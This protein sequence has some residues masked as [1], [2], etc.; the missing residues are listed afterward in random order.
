MRQI[1]TSIRLALSALLRSKIRSALTSLG[2]LIGIAAVVVVTALG[3]GARKIVSDQIESLGSNL[4]FVFYKPV[5]KSGAR[6][7]LGTGGGLSDRDAETIRR[8]ASAIDDVTVYSDVNAQ[9]VSEYGNG[10][11]T[12]VGADGS[13]FRVRSFEIDRGRAFT[14]S[15]E[16][17]KAK[18]VVIG[19]TAIEKLFGNLDPIGHWIRVGKHPFRI[20]GTLKTKGQS[21]FEDQDD[22]I[23]MP[24]GTWR[25]RVVP[26]NGDRI[27]LIMAT[28]K[29]AGANKQAVRQVDAILRQ[30]RGF[31]QDEEPDFRIRTQ[32]EF[33]KSQEAIFGILTALLLSVAAIS[34]FVGG[35]GVMNI[36]LVNVT[37]RTREIGIR[38]AI[39]AKPGDIRLQFLLESIVLTL[40]GG[41]A[42]VALAA[43]LIALLRAKLGWAMSVSP[44]AVAVAVATSVVVGLVFGFWPARRA[45][46]LDPIEALRH[47]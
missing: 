34:L 11:I 10:K 27:Q 21:P 19:P 14:D 25:S 43:G 18:V 12:V 47:E 7:R 2:I 24:I 26:T 23:I 9:V 38:M 5:T 37:E 6:G 35:V 17:T 45:A 16:Q 40:F 36:M 44:T 13:Y 46:R 8:E 4:L 29:S 39:G 31:L 3:T 1:L 15:E 42:G 28:A 41:F 22:R 32:E 30:R 33:Q 20:V